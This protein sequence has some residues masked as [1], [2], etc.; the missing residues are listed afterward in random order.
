MTKLTKYKINVDVFFCEDYTSISSTPISSL[1]PGKESRSRRNS[2]PVV[3]LMRT[4]A[5]CQ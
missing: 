4:V 1:S 2:K 5:V 3:F